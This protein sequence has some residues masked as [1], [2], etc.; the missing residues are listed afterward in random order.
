M[1]RSARRLRGGAQRDTLEERRGH[2]CSRKM[3]HSFDIFDTCICRLYAYPRDIF[4]ELGWRL[5]PADS[6]PRRR[7][8]YAQN[9]QRRRVLA[10]KIAYLRSGSRRT[11]SLGDIYA[12]FH[13]PHWL[14]VDIEEIQRRELALEREAMYAIPSITAAIKGLLARGERIIFI[15]DMYVESAFIAE[16]FRALHLHP[17]PARMYISSEIRA[18]KASGR[19]FEAVLDAEKIPPQD[20]RHI[21][22][23]LHSDVRIAKQL[24]IDATHYTASGLSSHEQNLAGP[25]R[26]RT[27]TQSRLAGLSRKWRLQ[28]AEQD[29]PP[30]AREAISYGT[31]APFLLNHVQWVLQEA[32]RHGVKRLYCVARDGQLMHTI[33]R[34]LAS[35]FPGVEVRYLYGSR[36]AWIPASLIPGD[37]TW[38]AIVFMGGERNAP[39]DILAR[40]GVPSADHASFMAALE[41]TNEQWRRDLSRGDAIAFCDALLACTQT[42]QRLHACAA[43]LRSTVLTYLTQEGLLDGTPWA[44][45]DVGWSFNCQAALNRILRTDPAWNG[46]VKGYYVGVGSTFLSPEVTGEVCCHV[47]E[48]GSIFARRRVLIEHVFTPATHAT[49]IGYA[50]D[51]SGQVCPR[52]GEDS[53]SEEELRFARRLEEIARGAALDYVEDER[54]RAIIDASTS[55]ILR[56]VKRLL[57]RPTRQEA[58]AFAPFGSIADI[59]HESHFAKPL[60]QAMSLRD[61]GRIASAVLR[62]RPDRAQPPLWIEGSATLSPFSVRFAA[63]SMLVLYETLRALRRVRRAARAG[64]K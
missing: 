36:R 51:S 38:K 45:V 24:G 34:Q 40:L 13:S 59:R 11:A 44:L 18:N 6:S 57:T 58:R 17:R 14:T 15:S 5:A 33:A 43:A 12:N 7:L 19:L 49:T 32:R 26:S 35:L 16:L 54:T 63:R 31:V 62:G 47:S 21:G 29:G 30:N 50:T 3:L 1:R 20:L 10:E 56:N 2:S 9:F 25:P 61:V 52:F 22:D 48:P 4:L 46:E 42:A 39:H 37:D 60:C 53:R 64:G 55:D 27:P 28:A 41:F 23:N 8:R